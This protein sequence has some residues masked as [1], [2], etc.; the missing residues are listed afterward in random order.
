MFKDFGAAKNLEIDVRKVVLVHDIEEI[1]DFEVE[2]DKTVKLK[3]NHLLEN[4]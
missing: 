3:Q 2:L 4:L 1:V